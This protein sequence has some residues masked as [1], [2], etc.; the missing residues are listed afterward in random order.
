MHY[1]G[2]WTQIAGPTHASPPPH[3][4]GDPSRKR[5]GAY[6]VQSQFQGSVNSSA[7]FLTAAAQNL[8]CMK[9]AVEVGAIVPNAWTTWFVVRFLGQCRCCWLLRCHQWDPRIFCRADCATI[10]QQRHPMHALDSHP[11]VVL[12]QGACVPAVC[13]LLLTPLLMYKLFPPEVKDTPDA[14]RLANERL[15][16]MGPMSRNETIMLGTMAVAVVLWVR[17]GKKQTPLVAVTVFVTSLLV[18]IRVHTHVFRLISHTMLMWVSGV[19]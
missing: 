14:P 12:V 10:R 2:P 5:L 9:L 1:L 19:R 6:L 7:L 15:A 16:K 17:M 11:C 8:L 18:R 3:L 4:A 13:G